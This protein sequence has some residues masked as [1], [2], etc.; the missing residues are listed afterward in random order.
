MLDSGMMSHRQRP[1]SEYYSSRTAS[2][3]S[4]DRLCRNVQGAPCDRSELPYLHSEDPSNL[5]GKERTGHG[6]DSRQRFSTSGA[7]DL[8]SLADPDL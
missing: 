4:Q 2:G 3:N 5:F 8:L 7:Y 6:R 1:P